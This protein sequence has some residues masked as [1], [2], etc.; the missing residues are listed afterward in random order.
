MMESPYVQ[1]RRKYCLN[2]EEYKY[3]HKQYNRSGCDGY[4]D[5]ILKCVLIFSLLGDEVKI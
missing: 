3:R 1:F 5:D 4:K 2:C